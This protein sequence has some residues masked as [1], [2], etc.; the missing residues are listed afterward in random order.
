MDVML[1]DKATFPR[2]K[3][4]GDGLTPRA[5]GVL[6][7]MQLLSKLLPLGYRADG[8]AIVGPKGATVDVA[9]PQTPGWF[10]YTL[11]VPRLTLDD[12]IRQRALDSGAQYDSPVRVINIQPDANGVVIRAD[13]QGQPVNYL[14]RMAVVATGASSGLLVQMG[15]FKQA[16]VTALAVRGYY[17]G[18]VGLGNRVHLRFD[19]VPLPGYGWLFPVTS[20][21]ANIGLGVF[22]HGFR[23]NR[24]PGS[25][26]AA[27][28]AFLKA[29]QLQPLLADTQRVGPVK[30]FPL[31]V[32]FATAPT[33]TQRV[34]LVGEA[35]GLVNPVTGEGIDYALHSGQLAAEH[36]RAM[37]EA[38]DFSQQQ[39]LAYDRILRRHFQRIFVFCT[40]T[41]NLFVN[42]LLFNRLVSTA[43]HSPEFKLQLINLILGNQD[44]ALA[45]SVRTLIRAAV[46]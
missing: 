4:C 19:D 9:F 28:D 10:D 30:G 5:L 24:Q 13:R 25:P 42:R 14:A 21:S 34:L 39:H 26:R 43:Q 40:W 2:D 18:V 12:I 22:P 27:F 44:P 32:D 37:F 7:D 3:T 23:G 35:A 11:V 15:M 1:L 45:M 33:F 17:E 36:L 8:M 41:R 46:A 6:N 38:G 16:P 31:R 20:T 29:P